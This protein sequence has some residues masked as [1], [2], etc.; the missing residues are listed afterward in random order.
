[1]VF[2]DNHGQMRHSLVSNTAQEIMSKILLIEDDE[3]LQA[4]CIH[5]FKAAGF[6]IWVARDGMEALSLLDTQIPDLVVLDLMLPKINGMDLL[7]QIRMRAA[8][9]TLQVIVYSNVLLAAQLEEAWRSGAN[10]CLTKL[11][12]PPKKLVEVIVKTLANPN[13]PPIHYVPAVSD[14]RTASSEC[15]L[16]DDLTPN[17][18][19]DGSP[20]SSNTKVPAINYRANTPA[21]TKTLSG[22]PA[23]TPIA[24]NAN[25]EYNA[26]GNR[27]GIL[28]SGMENGAKPRDPLADTR[29]R[30]FTEASKTMQ[31]LAQLLRT[32]AMATE[33]GDRQNALYEL[34]W[35][36]QALRSNAELVSLSSI[37]NLAGI[38]AAFCHSLQSKLGYF[39]NSSATTLEQGLDL[40]S[41]LC[42]SNFPLDPGNRPTPKVLL[43]D[44]DPLERDEILAALNGSGF[45]T[46]FTGN[47]ALADNWLR[48]N[49][50]HLVI[51]NS[52]LPFIPAL[53]LAR[54]MRRLPHHAATPLVLIVQQEDW[55]NAHEFHGLGEVDVIVRPFIGIEFAAK[56]IV[57]TLGKPS[58]NGL[59][60]SNSS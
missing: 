30:F 38:I 58:L 29:S 10:K 39:N 17:S 60:L 50:Y 8:T 36:A 35:K 42:A 52:N 7:K 24:I 6:E 4:L 45:R 32:A 9:A 1:M 55:G 16:F 22:K 21:P 11:D 15:Y 43:V 59:S 48:G 18:R 40:L 5:F 51:M 56:A 23:N 20:P 53:E 47:P 12:C 19:K 28:A 54:R 14:E 44:D 34:Y 49:P 41:R 57:K 31:H 3:T 27:G 46:E 33:M 26:G 13:P 25:F 37:A 2:L